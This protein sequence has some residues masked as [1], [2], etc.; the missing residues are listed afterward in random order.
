MNLKAKHLLYTFRKFILIAMINNV[1][2]FYSAEWCSPSRQFTQKL[3]E[4]YK[5]VYEEIKNK[6]DIVFV[7]S[8]H[9]QDGFDYYYKEMPWKAV[10]FSGNLVDIFTTFAW[11]FP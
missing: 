4:I 5:Q 1:V 10:P 11:S 3:T 2:Y 8:D 6:F 7:S 9:D